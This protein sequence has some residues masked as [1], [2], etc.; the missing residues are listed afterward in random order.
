MSGAEIVLAVVIF[1]L[2]AGNILQ[3]RAYAAER[4]DLLASV[5]ALRR[6]ETRAVLSRTAR[7]Y[8]QAEAV[9]HAIEETA[10]RNTTTEAEP[11]YEGFG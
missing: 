11:P 8:E 9:G 1:V 2:V 3:S 5:G 6:Q 10:R 4:R 7:E